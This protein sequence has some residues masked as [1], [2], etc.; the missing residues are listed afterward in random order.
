MCIVGAQ[1]LPP[2][3]KN[4]NQN[5]QYSNYQFTPLAVNPAL[6]GSD[7]LFRLSTV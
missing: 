5:F 1:I 3:T 4:K 6:V 2:V 7:G